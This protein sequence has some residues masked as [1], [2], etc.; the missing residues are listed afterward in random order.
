MTQIKTLNTLKRP[1]HNAF[2]TDVTSVKICVA[3]YFIT[4][5]SNDSS[6]FCG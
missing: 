6:Y 4:F 1:F 5:R 2:L 3:L